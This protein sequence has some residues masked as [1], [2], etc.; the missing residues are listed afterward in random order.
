MIFSI[1]QFIAICTKLEA[2]CKVLVS[3]K[4]PYINNFTV[5][6]NINKTQSNCI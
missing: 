6:I 5:N 4:H 1:E 3:A 2:C